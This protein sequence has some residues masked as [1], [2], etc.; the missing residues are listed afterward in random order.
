MKMPPGFAKV[1]FAPIADERIDWFKA[2]ID[3]A[4]GKVSSRWWHEGGKVHYEIITPVESTAV[5]EGQTHKLL[6]GKHFF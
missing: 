4:Y 3:T 5:I 2:E 6:P 1:H